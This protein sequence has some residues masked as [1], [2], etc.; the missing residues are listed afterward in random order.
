[1]KTLNDFII[2]SELFPHSKEHFELVKE[3]TE[4]HL[5]K[6]YLENQKFMLENAELIQESTESLDED[7]FM[8]SVGEVAIEALEEKVAEKAKVVGAKI[9]TIWD[10]IV[11]AIVSFWNG[12]KKMGT[13]IKYDF[14]EFVERLRADGVTKEIR[15]SYYDKAYDIIKDDNMMSEKELKR[16]LKSLVNDLQLKSF[17]VTISSNFH[18][19]AL[20][21]DQLHHLMGLI[22]NYKKSANEM[23][24]EM[25]QYISKNLRTGIECDPDIHINEYDKLD[26]RIREMY[27]IDINEDSGP[28][29]VTI[30][31]SISDTIA[32][33]AD[34]NK[35]LKKVLHIRHRIDGVHDFDKKR[36]NN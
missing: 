7:F 25:N 23:E 26:K 29:M 14:E 17:R 34:V 18:P 12:L 9:K 5:M 6:M 3:A 27:G 32:F 36:K 11:K 2:E 15:K 4:L 22:I 1:M 13:N 21:I 24:K 16:F 10:A 31:K 30:R 35:M 8:E 19:N 20:S 33:Y 28:A